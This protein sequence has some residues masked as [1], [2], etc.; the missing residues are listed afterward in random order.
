MA[1]QRQ[2]QDLNPGSSDSRASTNNMPVFTKPDSWAFG[3]KTTR[4]LVKSKS[5]YYMYHCES[6][7]L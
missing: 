5:A 3:L 1:D 2:R 7:L 4:G 6:L